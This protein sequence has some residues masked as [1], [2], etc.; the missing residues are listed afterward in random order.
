MRAG[1]ALGSNL[2]DRA[3]R[4]REARRHLFALHDG[5]GPFLCSRIYET[6]PQDCPPGS[7][8]FLNASIELHT[9]LAP[10]DLLAALQRIEHQ[11]G[12]PADHAFH[13][14]RTID[15][16]ILYLDNLG[17]VL[18]ELAVPH[19][20]IAERPFVLLPLADIAP[21]RL[22]P[23]FD[24]TPAALAAKIPHPPKAVGFF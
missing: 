13:A 23:G 1:I 6:E 10:L 3:A 22:L 11:L 2:G 18:P 12:R 19:P 9:A 21:N 5:S 15:L 8:A 7:P 4:L 16:D 14:P 17:F 20:R 24:E